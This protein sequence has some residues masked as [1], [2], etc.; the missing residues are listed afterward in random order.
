M[1]GNR[2]EPCWGLISHKFIKVPAF[3]ALEGQASVFRGTAG[4]K[5]PSDRLKERIVLELSVSIIPHFIGGLMMNYIIHITWLQ[6][7]N[8]MKK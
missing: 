4:I 7:R 1:D 3:M 6:A 2:D 8:I 5:A